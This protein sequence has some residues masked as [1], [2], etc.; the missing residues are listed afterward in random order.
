VYVLGLERV[1]AS[2]VLEEIARPVD[3]RS[4]PVRRT[5]ETG[6]AWADE[7]LSEPVLVT[8]SGRYYIVY[9]AGTRSTLS[10]KPFTER[11]FELVSIGV[12][13]LLFDRARRSGG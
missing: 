2:E 3:Q 9:T 5:V 7:S 10:E 12:G 8:S 4:K 6:S 1:N 13:I 11:V